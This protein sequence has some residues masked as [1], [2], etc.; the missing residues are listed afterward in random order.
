MA[1]NKSNK[2][3]NPPVTSPKPKPNELLNPPPSGDSGDS[4]SGPR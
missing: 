2:A 3:P 1:T 4:G